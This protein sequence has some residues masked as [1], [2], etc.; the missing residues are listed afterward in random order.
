MILTE[1]YVQNHLNNNQFT[2]IEQFLLYV[3][4]NSIQSHH[5]IKMP[6]SSYRS[7]MVSV[8]FCG[9]RQSM[10]KVFKEEPNHGKITIFPQKIFKQW[11]NT[12]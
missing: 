10:A 3:V 8:T 9:T 6:Q 5:L 2:G 1:L 4:Q 12:A 7:V 11:Y